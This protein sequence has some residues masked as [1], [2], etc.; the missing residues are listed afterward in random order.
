MHVSSNYIEL[1]ESSIIRDQVSDLPNMKR[2]QSNQRRGSQISIAKSG[3][4]VTSSSTIGKFFLSLEFNLV[5]FLTSLS[6]LNA[7]YNCNFS[8][9]DFQIYYKIKST[10]A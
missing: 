5:Y 9:F 10:A 7:L 1:L 2:K 8:L 4:T 3:I 6:L